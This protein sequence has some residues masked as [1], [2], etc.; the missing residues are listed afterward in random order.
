MGPQHQQLDDLRQN[1]FRFFHKQDIPETLRSTLM[2]VVTHKCG[3]VI[4]RGRR[5]KICG[6]VR[7]SK[8]RRPSQQ[9]QTNIQQHAGVEPERVTI[10]RSKVAAQAYEETARTADII[11]IGLQRHP[12]TN[13]PLVASIRPAPRWN[14]PVP[15][16]FSI[17]A[18]ACPRSVLSGGL[19]RAS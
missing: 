6:L 5:S 11:G 2:F 15:D 18:E 13:Q 17:L 12:T 9:W 7:V 8:R 10:C 1:E 14:Q 4:P 3:Q 16:H 19:L